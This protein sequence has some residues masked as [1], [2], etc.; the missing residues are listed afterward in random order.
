MEANYLILMDY[1]NGTLIK[2]RLS[3]EQKAKADTFEDYEDYIRT[4][5]SEYGFKLTDCEWM[6]VENLTEISY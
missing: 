2:I 5:E 1:S 4:L 6:T 3:D